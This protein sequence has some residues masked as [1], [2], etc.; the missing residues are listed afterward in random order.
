MR[1]EI[2][3]LADQIESKGGKTG[4]LISQFRRRGEEEVDPALLQNLP[5]EIANHIL[6]LAASEYIP[7]KICLLSKRHYRLFTP[8]LY[9]SIEISNPV[10]F[11]QL[12]MTL[13][14]HNR[15][16]GMHIKALSVASRTFDSYGYFPEGIAG[17]AAL[18]V[19]LEQILLAAPNLRHLY[20]DLFSLAAAHDG[21]V[22]R[23]QKGSSPLSL[24]TEYV[25]SQYLTLPIF[26]HLR[27]LDL[28]VFGLDKIAVDNLR[29]AQPQV[30]SLTIRWVNRQSRVF[31]EMDVSRAIASRSQAATGGP[32]EEGGASD[33]SERE[34]W[35]DDMSDRARGSWRLG[36]H[37]H[38]DFL[39]FVE[40]IEALRKWPANSSGHDDEGHYDSA[41]SASTSSTTGGRPLEALTILAWPKALRELSIYYRQDKDVHVSSCATFD[42]LNLD[43]PI[44]DH[45]TNTQ[46][47][48]PIKPLFDRPSRRLTKKLDPLEI[49]PHPDGSS[50]SPKP[51]LRLALDPSYQLG[52]RRGSLETWSNYKGR[53]W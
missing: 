17:S 44:W 36:G 28:T 12:R 46:D 50:P 16:L 10:M 20:L 29:Q 40:A 47:D 37:R 31:E 3:D 15:S 45:S 32:V 1:E 49:H 9:S 8:R 21:T 7:T 30:K 34:Q 14:L 38:H 33:D 13:A 27:H 5:I 26:S 4:N 51:L 53:C 52:P 39:L 2:V 42:T 25:A 35:N 41:A 18:G 23:M 6:S 43:D 19:G 48:L 24:T 22:S 11:R